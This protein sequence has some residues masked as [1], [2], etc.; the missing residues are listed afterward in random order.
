[1]A[2]KIKK[3]IDEIIKQRSKGNPA[4][5]EMTKAKFILKG[6]NPDKF[7][8]DS[9][10]DPVIIEKLL[11]IDE[12]LN[13]KKLKFSEVNIKSVFSEKTS[14]KEVVED[15]KNQ[16]EAFDAKLIIYFASSI[17][18]QYN[19]SSL[20]KEVFKDCVV[21]GCSTSGEIVSGKLLKNS[22]VVMAFNSNIISDVKVEVIENMK[23]KL[24]VEA[25]FISF[26]NYF[27]ESSYTMDTKRFVGIIL[28]DGIS[29]KEE[30]I[31]DLIGNRTNIFFVGGS[32]GD[33]CRFVKTHVCAN[34][35]AYSDSAVLLMIKM[36][37]NAEFSIIKTQSFK[38]LNTTLIAN[39]VNE[40]DREVME[41]NNKP[42][43]LAYKE[44]VGADSIE[45]AK[46]YFITNPVGLLVNKN[47]I[48]VR[49]P[50]YVKGT[51]MLFYCNILKD[52]EVRLLQSTNIIENTKK[53]IE[54]K[55]NEFGKIDG[56]INFNCIERTLEL[57]RKNLE[58]QYGELFKDI[59]TI[60]F[61]CYGEQFI[62]HINQTAT[63]LV[64]KSKTNI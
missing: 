9:E 3:I 6:I 64:F 28:I 53:A 18:D 34:G 55:I 22:V 37:D 33:D 62:G 51:S 59:P 35:K 31:M 42:A 19:L 46:K 45:D 24:N 29:K 48:F 7:D 56:I 20:M 57:E 8:S 13:A 60:G 4:I 41:F 38:C 43:I 30:K 17:F 23:E 36:N 16:L 44:A 39:K 10:D 61:S 14:E 15:I 25:A 26:D 5:K 47:E 12:Q 49:S 11:K 32:A 1:M 54:D 63:M 40:E 2:G 21:V 58:K 52:M 27:N 50:Q